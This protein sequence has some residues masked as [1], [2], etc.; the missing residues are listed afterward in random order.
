MNKYEFMLILDPSSSEDERNGTIE[1]I[2]TILKTEK[3]E[4]TKE[5]IWGDKK[6]AYT[7]NRSGRGFYILYTIDAAPDSLK[8]IT[9]EL[10]L[11]RNVWRHMF[12]KSED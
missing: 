1:I 6:L 5:D 11:E 7:I 2:K 8:I 3:V 9:K 10:N 12:V 4:I